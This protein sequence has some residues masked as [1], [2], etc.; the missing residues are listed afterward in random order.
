MSHTDPAR[1]EQIRANIEAARSR[2][3]AACA[4]ADRDPAEVSLVAVTKTHPASDVRVLSSLGVSNVGENRDQEAAPKAAAT[5]D[6]DL[7]WHFVG[8][9]Q[10][11]KARSVASYADVVH[12]VDRVKLARALGDRAADAGRRL[13][14][15]VQVDLDEE[16]RAGVLGPRGGVDPADALGIA[17]RI[18]EHE[19]LELGGVMAVAPLGGDPDAAFA[20]LYQVATRIRDRYSRATMIS[21][22]MSGDLEAAI[23]RGATHL[24]LGAALLGA[25]GTNVG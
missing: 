6:L 9:L 24:R 16:A 7:T 5:A 4:A 25:R 3:A 13:T 2:I 1:T 22:G 18:D 15:L 14:C 21:A 23:G 8:Q 10:T 19:A 11:N 17:E 12:S 20:R